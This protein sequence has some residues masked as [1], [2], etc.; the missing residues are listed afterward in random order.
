MFL[1]S[2]K[3]FLSSEKIFSKLETIFSKAETLAGI[4]ETIFHGF[5]ILISNTKTIIVIVQIMVGALRTL[6]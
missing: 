6:F 3:M 4:L 2:E 1:S 5:V